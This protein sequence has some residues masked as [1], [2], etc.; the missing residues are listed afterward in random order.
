MH[1]SKVLISS[2][3]NANF[4]GVKTGKNPRGPGS[5]TVGRDGAG[6]ASAKTVKGAEFN[7]KKTS[8]TAVSYGADN[9]P[10]GR[11]PN[12]GANFDKSTGV[13][14]GTFTGKAERVYV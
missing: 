1:S 2:E 9:I 7:T 5:A 12:G 14:G 10:S 3:I 13:G 6:G 4:G 11:T 8:S